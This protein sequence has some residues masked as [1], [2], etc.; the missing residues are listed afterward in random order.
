MSS[1]YALD[2]MIVVVNRLLYGRQPFR[3]NMREWN[4][5]VMD[6]VFFLNEYSTDEWEAMMMADVKAYESER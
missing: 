5:S 6:M 2:E 4:P 1:Y 3:V